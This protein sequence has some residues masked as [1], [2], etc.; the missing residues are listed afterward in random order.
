M[1]ASKQKLAVAG[2]TILAVI[3]LAACGAATNP[4]SDSATTVAPATPAATPR[5]V[6]P[7]NG[8]GS[9]GQ[10]PLVVSGPASLPGSDHQV[11][12][13][14]RTLIITSA[15]RHP[16][17]AHGTVLIDLNLVVRN[18]SGRPIK[19][20]PAFFQLIGP[21]GDSFNYQYKSSGTFYRPIG[22]RTSRAG[23]AEFE[24]PAAAAARLSL[25]YRPEVAR[26]TALIQLHVR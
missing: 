9:P 8:G 24:I 5:Q 7:K 23:L 11:V 22:A 6:T 19:N 18:T 3:C 25:L 14:D 16:G 26:D 4:G 1:D 12:L 21:E 13:R 10:G 17:P 15:T 2:G 20:M